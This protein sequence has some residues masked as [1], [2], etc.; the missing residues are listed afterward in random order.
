M[1][2]S[3]NLPLLLRFRFESEHVEIGEEAQDVGD[4]VEESLRRRFPRRREAGVVGRRRNGPA[5][6]DERGDGVFQF[7]S[8]SIDL[9][10]VFVIS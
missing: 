8:G 10:S 4:G 6:F 3:S 7:F 9:E 1:L 2:G 5:V